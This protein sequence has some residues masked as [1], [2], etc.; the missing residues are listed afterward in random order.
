MEKNNGLPNIIEPSVTAFQKNLDI[1][2][3]NQEIKEQT[4]VFSLPIKRQLA[5]TKSRGF[6]TEHKR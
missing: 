3:Q 6:S 5:L 2:I 4:Y 1:N